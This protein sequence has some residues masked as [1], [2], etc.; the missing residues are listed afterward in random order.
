MLGAVLA[1]DL[2]WALSAVAGGPAVAVLGRGTNWMPLRSQCVRLVEHDPISAFRKARASDGLRSRRR[3]R[4]TA[5]RT[6]SA[7]WSSRIPHP[8]SRRPLM[9]S[10]LHLSSGAI[11]PVRL[12]PAVTIIPY[13]RSGESHLASP[14]QGFQVVAS[15]GTPGFTRPAVPK[16]AT[17]SAA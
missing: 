3:P 13:E 10:K 9:I 1:A 15:R 17:Q 4:P 8:F 2:F 5:G 14:D 16:C 7:Q 6:I 11:R 12:P